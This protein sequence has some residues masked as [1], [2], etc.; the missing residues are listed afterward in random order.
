MA[1]SKSKSTS[2]K[3]KTRQPHDGPHWGVV[4]VPGYQQNG[5]DTTWYL[6]YGQTRRREKVGQG[7]TAIQKAAREAD[8]RNGA[9]RGR[10]R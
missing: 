10:V 5:S 7:P 6:V 3:K 8:R 2:S 4:S 9:A 1:R